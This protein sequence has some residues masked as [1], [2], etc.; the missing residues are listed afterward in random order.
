MEF[1]A[2]TVPGSSDFI[3][4]RDY[5]SYILRSIHLK[6]HKVLL[7][8]YNQHTAISKAEYTSLHRCVMGCLH[9]FCT[10]V[11]TMQLLV[12]IL[13]TAPFKTAVSR[14]SIY[15]RFDHNCRSLQVLL[16]LT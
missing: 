14:G 12:D 3:P 2:S 13:C 16:N 4:A 15:Q 7:L 10:T 11:D 8:L 1:A 9:P 5:A 6:K